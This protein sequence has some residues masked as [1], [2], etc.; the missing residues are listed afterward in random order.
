MSRLKVDNIEPRSGNNVAIDNPMN[1]KSYTTAQRDALSSPQA[2]DTIYNSETGTI[3]YYNGTAWFSSSDNTFVFGISYLLVAGGGAAG[4]AYGAGGGAGGM[5]EDLTGSKQIAKNT[6]LTVSVGGGGPAGGSGGGG[7]FADVTVSGG[8]YQ[9]ANG[10][11]G[12]GARG[13]FSNT[14]G[15]GTTGEGND[16]GNGSVGN[17]SSG[18]GGGKGAAGQNATSSLPGLGGIGGTT[19]I[20]T[21]AQATTHSVGEV[22]GSNVYFAGGGGGGGNL[23]NNTTRAG[24][25]GGGG[26]GR[27][28]WF[29]SAGALN[30]G[31]GTINTGGGGGGP[32][33]SGTAGLGGSGVVILRW[34][35]ADATIGSTRTGLVDSGVQTYGTDSYIV[36]TSGT[37]TVSF[38]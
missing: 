15:L 33:Q 16:G 19:T 29:E 21:T 9:Q 4:G 20:I 28:Y 10:G 18:G 3:D 17:K 13:Y 14:P 38:S 27:V 23:N 6:A 32:N 5:K 1:L 30:G 37:G 8:G 11:S 35:T 12:G 24:G 36:F 7:Q 34:A 2:G 22:D 26:L 31:N 25:K